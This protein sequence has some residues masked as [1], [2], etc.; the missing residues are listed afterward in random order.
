MKTETQKNAV[1]QINLKLAQVDV[2]IAE[3]K[4]IAE[5]AN[6]TFN[7]DAGGYGMGGTYVPES[8][9]DEWGMD[10]EDSDGWYAS[11]QSC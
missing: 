10:D 8:Q 7:L 9:R 6:V 1:M 3:A 4:A 5:E 2:L 11:S